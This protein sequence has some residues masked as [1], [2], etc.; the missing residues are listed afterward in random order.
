MMLK[1]CSERKYPSFFPLKK[2]SVSL[3]SMISTLIFCS[4]FFLIKL[5][6]FP[7]STGLVIDCQK[8]V[9]S[10]VMFT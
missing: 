4:V 5:K 6:K 7:S 10:F 9:L 8:W 2:S 3:E 1:N